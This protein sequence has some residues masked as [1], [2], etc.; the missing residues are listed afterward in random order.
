[1]VTKEKRFDYPQAFAEEAG[2]KVSWK[3]YHTEADA[4]RAAVVA[5]KEARHLAAQGYDFGFQVPGSIS[6]STVDGAYIVVVP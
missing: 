4:V 2:C 3:R 5:K 1:M 6:R